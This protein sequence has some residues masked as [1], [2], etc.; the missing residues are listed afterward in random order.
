MEVER[1]EELKYMDR[2]RKW[3]PR[4]VELLRRREFK[5]RSKRG[6]VRVNKED[7]VLRRNSV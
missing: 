2:M 1:E 5:K 6:A 3:N 4:V 7:P